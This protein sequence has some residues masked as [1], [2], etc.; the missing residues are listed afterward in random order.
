[1]KRRGLEIMMFY[2][3]ENSIQNKIIMK[4]FIANTELVVWTFF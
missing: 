2:L 3:V 1:M 4:A